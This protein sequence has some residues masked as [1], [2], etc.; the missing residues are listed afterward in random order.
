MTASADDGTHS[1]ELRRNVEQALDWL[2]AAI[3]I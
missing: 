3:A 1:T 2:L